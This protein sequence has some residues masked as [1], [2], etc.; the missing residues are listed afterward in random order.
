VSYLKIRNHNF[1]VLLSANLLLLSLSL[2]YHFFLYAD[3]AML[4]VFGSRVLRRIFGS[5]RDEVTVGWRK[6]HNEGLHDLHSSPSIITRRMI[7]SR[8]MRWAG[9]VARMAKKGSAYRLFV[10]KPEGKG[11]L[12]SP[13]RRWVDNIKMDLLELTWGDVDWIGLVQDRNMCRALVNS[14]FNPRIP[15]YAGK[16]SCVLTTGGLSTGAQ[17]HRVNKLC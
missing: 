3:D 12:G 8:R 16:L 2:L 11:S 7:K 10:V 6:L 5:K 4:K 13:R 14:V 9:H 17:L 15:Y 1:F